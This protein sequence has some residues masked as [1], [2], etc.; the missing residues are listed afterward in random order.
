MNNL[1]SRCHQ[2]LQYIVSA[3]GY[4][5]IL[6][7][8]SEFNISKR[9]FYYDLTK[10]NDWCIHQGIDEI[11]VERLKGI[12]LT[13]THK[14]TISEALECL[15]R[16]EYNFTQQER[17]HIIVSEI[18]SR[19][20]ALNIDYF[21][22]KLN[23]SRNTI[24]SDIK[25]AMEEVE[26]RKLQLVYESKYG[27]MIKGDLIQ[28]CSM[29]FLYFSSVSQLYQQ[30]IVEIDHIERV[31]Q[32][33]EKLATVESCLKTRYVSGVLY[34]I[35]VFFGSDTLKNETILFSIKDKMEI[36]ST[37]EFHLVQEYFNEFKESEQ[38][39]LALHLLGSRLQSI[40]VNLLNGDDQESYEY[41]RLLVNEFSF[42]ACTKLKNQERIIE[43]LAAHLKTSLYR[44]RYGIQLE[45]PMLNAVKKE[46]A[47]LFD[48]TLR[49]CKSMERVIGVPIPDS[50]VAY[51][52]LHF[53]GC[54][55]REEETIRILIV[56]PNGISTG[57]MLREEVRLLVPQAQ[58]IDVIALAEL[59]DKKGYDLIIS[60]IK[61]PNCLDALVVHPILTDT[62]RVL[63][64]RSCLSAEQVEGVQLEQIY[65]I[66]KKYIK[67]ED[68]ESFKKEIEDSFLSKRVAYEQRKE[69]SQLLNHLGESNY[70]VVQ[71]EFTWE[72][73]IQKVATVLIEDK[74]IKQS[75]VDAIVAKTKEYGTYM[76]INKDVVLAH[77]KV[78]DG[79]MELGISIGV[80]ETPVMFSTQRQARIVIVLAPQDQSSH[81]GILQDIFMLFNNDENTD[82]IATANTKMEFIE[83]IKSILAV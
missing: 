81:F 66:A 79:S 21:I 59:V 56:C 42:I 77:A 48:I 83:R 32:I 78:E 45:N 5:T 13:L 43:A 18:L 23:V 64:M 53:G 22:Q 38:Y 46:Y 20:K 61:I 28:K 75:Y 82:L 24:L 3:N 29:F 74:M 25:I 65:A 49:A 47:H 17:I 31:M 19:T 16:L 55:T 8:C 67:K 71:G 58:I 76:F 34:S 12:Y 33:E 7:L 68:I 69:E 30:N 41:A 62:D 51:I 80:F 50:E 39:Y 57:N 27:Y 10:I 73:S 72:Q 15:P 11:V 54:I 4:I 52:T 2:I 70:D 37:E 1:D 60:T 35:A 26:Q 44:Y 6:E 9:S 36:S 14:T 40:P 63:I